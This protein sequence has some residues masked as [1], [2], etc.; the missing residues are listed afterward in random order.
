MCRSCR[1]TG[2][3]T[4]ERT[5][6]IE[7]PATPR[8]QKTMREAGACCISL[9]RIVVSGRAR[10][11]FCLAWRGQEQAGRGRGT[12]A[13]SA[14][15]VAAASQSTRHG[16]RVRLCA[17]G[18]AALGDGRRP[19]RACATW[20][21]GA[22]GWPEMSVHVWGVQGCPW[23]PGGAQ[24]RE[25][26]GFTDFRGLRRRGGGADTHLRI[27]LPPEREARAHATWVMA[28]AGKRSE[29]GTAVTQNSPRT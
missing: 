8:E 22:Q 2:S 9:R 19:R 11:I 28:R 14:W 18:R 27:K 23:A 17:H 5:T 21:E 16:A 24:T 7:A 15:P 3:A 6:K 13:A 25:F 12:R 10:G 1:W 26:Y 4:S 20:W 29:G